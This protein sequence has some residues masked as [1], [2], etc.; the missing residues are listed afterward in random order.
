MSSALKAGGELGHR[1][2]QQR[3]ASGEDDVPGPAL[4][5]RLERLH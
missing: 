1:A 3:L 2:K 4:A 5:E